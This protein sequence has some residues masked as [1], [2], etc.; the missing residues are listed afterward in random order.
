MAWEIM[1][2]GQRSVKPRARPLK[3]DTRRPLK[4]IYKDLWEYYDL[5]DM[6]PILVM[7]D[8]SEII[9]NKVLDYLEWDEAGE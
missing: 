3:I 6:L 7:P 1:L 4:L 8:R 2:E 5:N 9:V